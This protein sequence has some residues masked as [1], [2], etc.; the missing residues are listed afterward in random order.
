MSQHAA[1][2]THEHMLSVDNDVVSMK[3]KRLDNGPI[4]AAL[5]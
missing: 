3:S 5:R 4:T 1:E 2:S